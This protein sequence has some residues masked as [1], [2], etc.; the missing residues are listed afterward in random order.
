LAKFLGLIDLV[1]PSI[2]LAVFAGIGQFFQTKMTI[3]KIEPGKNKTSNFSSIMQKQM[4]YFFPIFTVF[5]LFKLP[6]AIGL[7]WLATTLFTIIQQYFT[8][9]D[10]KQPIE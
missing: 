8:L 10:K 9:R 3:P 5:I 7:Y 4:K 6:S 1:K 2:F